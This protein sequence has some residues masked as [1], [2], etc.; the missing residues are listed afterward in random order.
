[1]SIMYCDPPIANHLLCVPS[2]WS[3]GP[4][5]S[6]HYHTF[7]LVAITC[8][9]ST[10]ASFLVTWTAC[11]LLRI[12]EGRTDPFAVLTLT[13]AEAM[14]PA[15]N[16]NCNNAQASVMRICVHVKVHQKQ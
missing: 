13:L 11:A 9:A 10:H 12:P 6:H 15:T 16:F 14:A 2:S 8:L 1:M 5:G 4:K 3:G 7:I